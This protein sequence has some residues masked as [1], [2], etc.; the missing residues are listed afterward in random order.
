MG[1]DELSGARNDAAATTYDE[2]AADATVPACQ[3]RRIAQTDKRV[4]V[5]APGWAA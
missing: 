5:A 3:P 4:A 1:L 2:F